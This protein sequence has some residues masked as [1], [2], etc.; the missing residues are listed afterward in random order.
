MFCQHLG[1][2]WVGEWWNLKDYGE[3]IIKIDKGLVSIAGVVTT[4]GLKGLFY[5]WLYQSTH[6]YDMFECH[7]ICYGHLLM[8]MVLT[9]GH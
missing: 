6:S 3:N 2:K 1:S 5:L 9:K 7:G 8:Y 4:I